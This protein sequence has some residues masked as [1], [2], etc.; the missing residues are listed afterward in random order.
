MPEECAAVTVV[1]G[2]VVGDLPY[3][4]LVYKIAKNH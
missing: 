2:E 1:D 4:T 3:A